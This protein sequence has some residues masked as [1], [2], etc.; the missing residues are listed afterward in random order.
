MWTTI[1]GFALLAVFMT[2]LLK[3]KGHPIAL[4][5]I[6]P[7]TAALA[8]GHNYSEIAALIE[9]GVAQTTPNAIMFLFSILFFC[10]MNEMGIFD[11]LIQ[12]LLKH[13][14]GNVI[15]VTVSTAL[16][17]MIAHLDSST[18]STCLITIPAVVSLYRALNIR[19]EALV[20]IVCA[21]MGV[22][23]LT[24]W[25]GPT[26]RV[27][28]VTGIDVNYLWM[29]LIPLQLVCAV[30]VIGLA[31]FIGIIERRRGAGPQAVG[32]RS[33][34]LGAAAVHQPDAPVPP[35]SMVEA[36]DV[37][38][39]MRNI[40]MVLAVVMIASLVALGDVKAYI[41]FMIG[42]AVALI[43]NYPTLKAQQAA[44]SK[45]S[46]SA[47]LI[48]GT[49]LASG[50]FVGV[51]N[52]SPDGAPSI[53]GSMADALMHVMPDAV[54]QY[55]HIIFGVLGL[56]IGMAMGADAWFYG[57]LPLGIEIG[58]NYG[59]SPEAMGLG[60]VLGKNMGLILS[61]TFATTYLAIGLAG[62]ELKDYIRY[63]FKYIM[64][65]TCFAVLFA[66]VWGILPL[67]G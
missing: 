37:S 55:T 51:L 63:S 2:L 44:L 28:A 20:C 3:G 34:D 27:S 38:T 4:F 22:T 6:L 16:I 60:F 45:H 64:A 23:N 50:V 57:V 62:I 30:F 10:I 54:A 61:P 48:A 21:A 14:R 42:A 41:L 66:V 65:L 8:L 19:R 18:A 43:I 35:H 1:V 17:A 25:G 58:K 33:P 31:V 7:I 29:K 56:P 52:G 59:I 40:N 46:P 5:V 39:R 9:K 47:I 36:K 32:L 11:P 13:S 53:V 49:M 67:H 15:A 12:F 26:A 24:P